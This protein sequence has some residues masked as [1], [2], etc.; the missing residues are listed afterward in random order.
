MIA[1][2]LRQQSP[3][4]APPPWAEKSDAAS[5]CKDEKK[6][7]EKETARWELFF[8]LLSIY[9]IA[10]DEGLQPWILFLSQL[11]VVC[12]YKDARRVRRIHA[13][14][15][16]AIFPLHCARSTLRTC[17]FCKLKSLKFK[18]THKVIW[19]VKVIFIKFLW[20]TK[21]STK[22][23]MCKAYWLILFTIIKMDWSLNLG[24]RRSN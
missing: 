21:N 1:G 24:V 9:L 14:L 6:L 7:R 13:N 15:N 11:R 19:K 5:Y 10:R 22:G 17:F 3:K 16:H 4:S 18:M 8:G 2:W 23:K 20:K 12:N